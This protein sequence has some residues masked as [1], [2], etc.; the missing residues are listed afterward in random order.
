M[1]QRNVNHFSVYRENRKEI[2]L[3]NK[4]YFVEIFW[5]GNRIDEQKTK[6]KIT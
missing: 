2:C 6:V 1:Y 3:C 5:F 4:F